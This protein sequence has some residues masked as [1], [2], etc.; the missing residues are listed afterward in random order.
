[1]SSVR[2]NIFATTAGVLIASHL[3]ITKLRALPTANIK[4]GN[5]RS[6]GVNPCHLAC[7]K[8]AKV[9]A[10]LG[11]VFTMIMKQMVMPRKTSSARKRVGLDSMLTLL[12]CVEFI[13]Y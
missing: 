11:D 9:K 13:I 3:R 2:F 6:V 7:S 1:M 5:T 10:S 12:L 8:G 4:E